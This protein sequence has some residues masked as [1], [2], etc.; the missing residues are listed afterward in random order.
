[1]W[2]CGPAVAVVELDV[3][4]AE[5]LDVLAVHTSNP[6]GQRVRCELA[7]WPVVEPPSAAGRAFPSDGGPHVLGRY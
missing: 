2:D 4:V 5:S 1:M 3:L 7:S 6:M